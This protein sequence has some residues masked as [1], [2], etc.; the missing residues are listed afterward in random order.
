MPAG[1]YVAPGQRVRAPLQGR[2]RVGLVVALRPDDE[3]TLQPI[4]AAVESVPIVSPSTLELTRWAAEQSL[5]S[6]G[7][8]ALALL[9]PPGRRGELPV[10]PPPVTRAAG[11]PP[12]P[13]CWIDTRREDRLAEAVRLAPGPV[14]V[15][16]P[17]IARS[18]AL[19]AALDGQRLDSGVGEDAR[20]SGWFA[21]ARGRA[22]VSVGTRSALLVPLPPPA[23]LVLVDEHDP[24]HKPPGPP[25]LHSRE[26]LERRA[27]VEAASLLSLS[28]TPAVETWHAMTSGAYERVDDGAG[29]WPEVVIADPRGVLRNHPLTLPLT[30]AIEEATR[31]GQS[32]ALIAGRNAG[33]LGCD[34]CGLVLRCPDC[35]I[36]LA[37]SRTDRSLSCRLCAR[38]EPVP[39][40]CPGCRS[41]RLSQFGWSPERIETSLRK[42][43]PRLRVIRAA[44]ATASRGRAAPPSPAG[45]HV[46]VGTPALLRTL[47]R[48]RLASVGFVA[49]DPLLG[50]P[51]FRAGE[52][53]FQ[54][55]WAAA[56][57][58]DP[59]GRLIV[60]THHPE[61]PAVQAVR[62]R[63]REQFY[64]PELRFREESGYPPFRRLC[65]LEIRGRNVQ[66]AGDLAARCAAAVSGVDGLTVY[67]PLPL[68]PASTRA[69]RWRLLIK[70]DAR[71]PGLLREPLLP[72]LERGRR[73]G[74]VVEIEMDPVS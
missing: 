8:T 25:R 14:L 47:P 58:L 1:L 72:Y 38:Q 34:D 67:A 6:W 64:R 28:A 55:L 30:R 54:A 24:G 15:I 27:V 20:R 11:A 68:G 49:L 41:H 29:G 26:L 62:H 35:G 7:A 45:A 18:A 33:A 9:P 53:A 21:A 12:L 50:A 10:A 57:A 16:A 71:L 56:E 74:G 52:R 51:D 13:Q 31:S 32:A 5:S 36:A 37:F 4:H 66:V 65:A 23:T 3:R 46:L 22:R 48:R 42:R 44:E 73:G 70:G 2:V 69:T 17:D 61:H 43:F 60:Q 40:A 19:A 59:A 63:D 39:E